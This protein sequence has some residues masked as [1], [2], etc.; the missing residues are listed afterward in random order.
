MR[1]LTGGRCSRARKPQGEIATPARLAARRSR[2]APVL[3]SP[4]THEAKPVIAAAPV[5]G[6]GTPQAGASRAWRHAAGGAQH[7]VGACALHPATIIARFQHFSHGFHRRPGT[8]VV[9]CRYRE[10]S[11]SPRRHADAA[12]PPGPTIQR[13]I[14][15]GILGGIPW[16]GAIILPAVVEL[17]QYGPGAAP[18]PATG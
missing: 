2:P 10:R 13:A 17:I 15:G 8:P 16:L 1:L 14:S 9:Q 18:G 5:G 6:C 3:L 11:R 4:H 12:S 7:A